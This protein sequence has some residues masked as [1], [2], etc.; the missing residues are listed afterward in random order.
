MNKYLKEFIKRGVAF[1]GLG[2][3]VLG[4]V[5]AI[6][7]AC[8]EGGITLSGGEILLGVTSTYLLAFLQAGATVFNQIEEWSIA[9]SLFCHLGT[10]YI[11][12]LLAYLM[13]SWI[14]HDITVVLIFTAIFAVCF[15]AIWLTVFLLVRA[16]SR[17]MTDRLA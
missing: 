15:F 16:A 4:I 1:S 10:V 2:P 5:L 14:P 17:K 13:N 6:I 9:K 12:Y 11:A 7:S 8:T 3:I